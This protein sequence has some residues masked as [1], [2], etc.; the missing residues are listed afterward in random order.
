MSEQKTETPEAKADQ[1][2]APPAIEGGEIKRLSVSQVQTFDPSQ[3]GGCPRKWFAEKKL[4]RKPPATKAQ[5]AGTEGHRQIEHYLKTGEDVL[6]PIVRAGKHFLPDPYID[7]HLAV[8]TGAIAV[9]QPFTGELEASGVP[10]VGSIDLVNASGEYADEQGERRAQADGEVEVVD[11][12]TSRNVDRWAKPGS[13]LI[14]TVQM[15]GYGTFIAR[16]L[17][18]VELVRLSH[19]TFQTE[20]R[21]KAVK[22]TVLVPVE[23]ILERWATVEGV[24]REMKDVARETDIEKVPANWNACGAYGGCPHRDICPRPVEVALRAAFG[25]KSMGLLSNLKRMGTPASDAGASSTTTTTA[26]PAPPAQAAQAAATTQGAPAA[27]KAGGLLGRMGAMRAP[28]A[29]ANLPPVSENPPVENPEG[30]EEPRRIKAREARQ[31]HHYGVTLSTGTIATRFIARG[32]AGL[33]FGKLEGGG[34]LNLADDAEVIV[35]GTADETAVLPAD[36]PYS[37]VSGPKAE[38][39][40]SE[41]ELAVEAAQAAQARAQAPTEDEDGEIVPQDFKDEAPPAAAEEPKPRRRG[42]PPGS[43]NKPKAQAPEPAPGVSGTVTGRVSYSDVVSGPPK[44]R[45][46]MQAANFGVPEGVDVSVLDNIVAEAKGII[47][48]AQN[49]DQINQVS[50]HIEDLEQAAAKVKDNPGATLLFNTAADEIR[51]AAALRVQE[52]A[53]ARTEARIEK[54]LPDPQAGGKGLSVEEAKRRIAVPPPAALTVYVDAYPVKGEAAN[55][56]PYVQGVVRVIC[57]TFKVQ[58]IRLGDNTT[59]LGYGKWKA[60][61]QVA[62]KAKPPEAGAWFLLA[63]GNEVLEC[64]AQALVELADVAVVGR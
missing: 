63:R 29:P 30:V 10:F 3:D 40:K 25:A 45:G 8:E 23:K 22:S 12:K 9:E 2:P 47:D 5:V 37:G 49:V 11:W 46:E 17:P 13:A 61:L 33:A 7:G 18:G 31:G 1:A 34:V 56:E 26:P 60:C 24:V 51:D 42:R 50:A 27:P 6:G 35:L 44:S 20:G 43:K 53:K 36:A 21:P 38:G 15:P 59:P 28:A 41:A 57:E 52:I 14:R 58:D 55:L 48:A 39:Q 64:A 54:A 19:T 4:G 62:I 32:K 16:A